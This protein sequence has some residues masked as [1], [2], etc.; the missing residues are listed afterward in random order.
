MTFSGSLVGLPS[1]MA[2]MGSAI[3]FFIVFQIIY[4][5]ITPHHEFKLIR[6]GN[7]AAAIALGGTLIGFA[8]PV[9]NVIAHA[10]SLMD[11]A[12]WA[13]VALVVQLLSFIVTSLTMKTLSARIERDEVAAG[14]YMAAV[15][16]SVGMLN[17]ACMTPA[18]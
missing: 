9:S 10:T 3:A 6:Q 15:S 18:Y 16:V 4:T 2:Y 8:L 14:I 5:L 13:T 11:F 1:F 12:I 7:L 17:A